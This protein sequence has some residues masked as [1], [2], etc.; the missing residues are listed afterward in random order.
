MPPFG[1]GAQPAR[2][3][4]G[5]GR[6]R[7]VNGLSGR[8]WDKRMA[9]VNELRRRLGLPPIDHFFDQMDHARRHLVLT[10]EAFD[11]PAQLPDRVRYV[12]AVLDD[13]AW[14]EDGSWTPPPG[15]GPLVLVALSSSFQDQLGC[16]QRIIDALG[17]LP[18]RAVVTT[19]PAVDPEPLAAPANVRVVAA[20]P[21]SEVLRHA[22]VL[23]THGGHGTV[24]RALA[25]DVPMVILHHGRDQADNAARVEAR[26]AGVSVKRNAAAPK[27]A[28][29]VQRVLD[30][31]SFGEGAAR[32]GQAIRTDAAGTALTDELEDLPSPAAGSPQRLSGGPR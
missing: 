31:P 32:L 7:L 23:V 15:D 9:D 26:G 14:A 10:S 5:R 25:A 24:V 30:D 29:A 27:I 19:G 8:L 13:P 28:A 2:G 20:A 21:H 12:G 16:L 1:L 17:T 3:P 22:A 6:D 18:V 11:F 4:L